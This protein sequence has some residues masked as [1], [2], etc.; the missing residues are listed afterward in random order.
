[1][2]FVSLFSVG[3][4]CF[5]S[6][7]SPVVVLGLSA[8]CIR[9]LCGGCGGCSDCDV[10]AVVCV[11]CEHADRVRGF[12]GDVNVGVGDG[13]GVVAV[14]VWH[15]YVGGKHGSGIVSSAADV[16]GTSVVRGTMCM[17]LARGGVGGEGVSR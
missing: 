12:E 5:C 11:G 6:G 1:M 14:S 13:G 2:R 10:C 17:C 7:S 15:E 8:R 16:H 9:T 3:S 4:V